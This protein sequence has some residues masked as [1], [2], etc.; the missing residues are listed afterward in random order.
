MK[1]LKE[2]DVL[3]IIHWVSSHS[4]IK[5][6]EKADRLIKK[7]VNQLKHTQIDDYSS[8]SYIQRLV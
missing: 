1:E 3:T 5:G 7:A 4:D 2:E 6:N 8:F